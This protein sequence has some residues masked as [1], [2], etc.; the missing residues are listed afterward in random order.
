SK[1]RDCRLDNLVASTSVDQGPNLNTCLSNAYA[2]NQDAFIP[3]GQY[4]I[5]TPVN[6][7]N[8]PSMNVTGC[9]A[10]QAWGT[11]ISGQNYGTVQTQLICNTRATGSGICWDATGS[12]AQ[13]LKD[14]SLCNDLAC[15]G[16]SISNG[17]N[18][19]L[20]FGRDNAASNPGWTTG[21][22]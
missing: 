7:T 1:E 2:N 20:L 11:S 5:T 8:K 9:G 13:R 19:G 12:G 18:V 4:L 17:S 21:T 14:F 10:A 3:C 22:G 15:S 6:D 16:V